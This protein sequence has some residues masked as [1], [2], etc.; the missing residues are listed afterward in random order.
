MFCVGVFPSS[1]SLVCCSNSSIA[2]CPAPL[3]ACRWI[4]SHF[5][6]ASQVT[7]VMH[8]LLS[9]GATSLSE[10]TATRTQ[11]DACHRCCAPNEGPWGTKHVKLASQLT[12]PS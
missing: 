10:D 12:H 7:S 5:S 9:P 4:H 2:A 8:R 11:L 3:A 6:H 1:T